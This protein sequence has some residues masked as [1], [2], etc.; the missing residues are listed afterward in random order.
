[1]SNMAELISRTVI[2]AGSAV[3]SGLMALVMVVA[4]GWGAGL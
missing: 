1:M 3:A 2:A 4:G